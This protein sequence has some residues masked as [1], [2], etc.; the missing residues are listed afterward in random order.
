[1]SQQE[2]IYIKKKV[3]PL[4]FSRNDNGKINNK[5]TEF[6]EF[7]EPGKEVFKVE[8]QTI[9]MHCVVIVVNTF[10]SKAITFSFAI[11]YFLIHTVQSARQSRLT[12][13]AA[14]LTLAFN[15]IFFYFV[16]WHILSQ[17]KYRN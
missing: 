8:N 7:D 1:M 9:K 12:F 3:K 2:S 15:K 6:I 16:N 5:F 14:I 13:I 11:I 10:N 17:I 4:W